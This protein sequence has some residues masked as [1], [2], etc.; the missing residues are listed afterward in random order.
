MDRDNQA[1]AASR[2]CG[3]VLYAATAPVHWDARLFN[4]AAR[5]SVDMSS[6]VYF[7]HT[8]SDGGTVANRLAD[9]GY[10]WGTYGENIAAGQTSIDQVMRDLL[11]SPGHCAIVMKKTVTAVGVACAVNPMSAYKMYWSMT[12]ARPAL[13]L[14]GA[15]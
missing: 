6:H 1:R 7:S 8:G 11:N 4:A 5:H 13:A 9:A 15:N 10:L 14:D 12:F 3:Q 2:L